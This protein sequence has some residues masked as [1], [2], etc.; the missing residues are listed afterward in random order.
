MN[1]AGY[2]LGAILVVFAL[3]LPYLAYL[4]GWALVQIYQP[5]FRWLWLQTPPGR[6]RERRRAVIQRAEYRATVYRMRRAEVPLWRALKCYEGK[7]DD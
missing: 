5:A 1:G 7:E 3:F 6:Q 4:I 2:F